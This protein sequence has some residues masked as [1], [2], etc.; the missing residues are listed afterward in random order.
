MFLVGTGQA[1]KIFQNWFGSS[2]M[3]ANHVQ[4]I[5]NGDKVTSNVNGPTIVTQNGI[6]MNPNTTSV[7]GNGNGQLGANAMFN[8]AKMASSSQK[9]SVSTPGNAVISSTSLPSHSVVCTATT[10]PGTTQ[11]A[12]VVMSTTSPAQPRLPFAI[13]QP[14]QTQPS[15]SQQLI[16][17]RGTVSGKLNTLIIYIL[18][19]LVCCCVIFTI[20]IV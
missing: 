19:F 20:L 11:A 18:K 9:K 5:N 3:S 7:N 6:I 15:V 13:A 8:L 12:Q 17:P 14:R 10:G 2:S 4:I 1:E 16:I